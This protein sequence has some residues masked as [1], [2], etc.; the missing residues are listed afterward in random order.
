ME[1]DEEGER[2]RE[3]GGGGGGSGHVVLK[4]ALVTS[5]KLLWESYSESLVVDLWCN[6][7]SPKFPRESYTGTAL[8]F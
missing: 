4:R 7:M 8:V 2:E 3:R 6:L 1:I 5:L